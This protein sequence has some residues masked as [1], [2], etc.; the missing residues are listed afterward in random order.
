MR[1]VNGGLA[2]NSIRT[3]SVIFSV[4]LSLI[5][6]VAWAQSAQPNDQ[7]NNGRGGGRRQRNNRGDQSNNNQQTPNNNPQ[8]AQAGQNTGPR[9][10]GRN[11]TGRGSGPGGGFGGGFGG[12]MGGP[13][14]FMGGPGGGPGRPDLSTPESREQFYSG[15]VDRYADRIGRNYEL[16]DT[17]KPQVRSQLEKLKAQ[18]IEYSNQHQQELDALRQEAQQLRDARN[19]GQT[20]DP[21]RRRQLFSKMDALR[22]DSP[23][24]NPERVIQEIEKLLPPEQVAKGRANFEAER[25]Q[26]QQQWQQQR[27]GRLGNNAASQPAGGGNPG[28]GRGGRNAMVD[29]S[30]DAI[31]PQ[32]RRQVIQENPVGPWEQYLRDFIRQYQLDDAQQ[33]TATSVLREMEKR[34]T[35]YE[36]AHRADYDSTNKITNTAD[37]EKKLAELNQVVVL[38]FEEL[39]RRLIRVPTSA[40]LRAVGGVTTSSPATSQPASAA[41]S[42]Q[43]S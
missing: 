5:T 11:N 12:L 29:F 1:F 31:G 23:L 34:R 39:K 17:Q 16:N 14:G 25:Q 41:A 15:M 3:K 2:V 33:A 8:D 28:G 22:Q 40:Q 24:M 18:Q 13:G 10:G 42:S 35:T 20:V 32:Q 30:G 4:I 7:Q 6:A 21:E 19:N 38:Q 37:R 36:Q 43:P 9:G 27:Q 26:L